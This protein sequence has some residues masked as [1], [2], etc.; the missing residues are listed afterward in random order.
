MISRCQWLTSMPNLSLR[1]WFSKLRY[2]YRIL[3]FTT[4][5]SCHHLV[6]I[7]IFSC[8]DYANAESFISAK[9][10]HRSFRN[11][12]TECAI[13]FRTDFSSIGTV[14][15]TVEEGSNQSKINLRYCSHTN[16]APVQW[17]IAFITSLYLLLQMNSL[18]SCHVP[19]LSYMPLRIV[20]VQ[21]RTGQFLRQWLLYEETT[22][23]KAN[24]Y[25]HDYRGIE[26][27]S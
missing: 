19:M 18:L 5:D 6:R 11:C 15:K 17:H 7:L 13:V 22:A 2:I 4:T 25:Y 14:V 27:V 21:L 16:C 10:L 24:H 26:I 23:P 3:R 8:S 9:W 12:K 1:L 20:T